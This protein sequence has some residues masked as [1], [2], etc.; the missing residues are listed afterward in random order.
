MRSSSHTVLFFTLV[1]DNVTRYMDRAVSTN[2]PSTEV[3]SVS[4]Y[5]PTTVLH[6]QVSWIHTFRLFE[7]RQYFGICYEE[8]KE[9][10]AQST[11]IGSAGSLLKF[12]RRHLILGRG[13][14]NGQLPQDTLNSLSH[15]FSVL[16]IF[17][18]LCA[19]LGLCGS[20]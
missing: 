13:L 1:S 20:D 10:R 5:S 9:K 19:I 17:S 16:P 6:R 12:S 2:I 14:R 4:A 18:Y 15:L 8:G 11:L 3:C 7:K